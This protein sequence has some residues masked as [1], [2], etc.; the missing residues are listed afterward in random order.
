MIVQRQSG[1]A[2]SARGDAGRRGELP[3]GR[4]GSRVSLRKGR[5]LGAGLDLGG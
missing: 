3:A 5:K 2:V 1:R 4:T